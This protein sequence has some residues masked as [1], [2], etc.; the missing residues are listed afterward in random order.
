MPP[1]QKMRF[2]KVGELCLCLSECWGF[3]RQQFRSISV[4]V[5]WNG[6]AF[7]FYGSYEVRW[8][9]FGLQLGGKLVLC[10]KLQR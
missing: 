4:K 10:L 7:K 9:A 3:L 1:S 6:D 5:F 8:M 2:M